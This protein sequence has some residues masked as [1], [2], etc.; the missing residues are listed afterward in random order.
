MP[1]R[2]GRPTE[3]ESLRIAR[4]PLIAEL[5]LACAASHAAL[6]LPPGDRNRELE[7]LFFRASASLE[8]FL[9]DW[10]VRCLSFDT[11]QFVDAFER[12]AEN[13]ALRDLGRWQPA[14]RLWGRKKRKPVVSVAIP[15]DNRLS[16]TEASAYLGWGGSTHSFRD[17]GELQK[18]AT[19][20]LALRFS[21]RVAQLTNGQKR[22]LDG[23]IKIRNLL[24][25]R[26][27]R[28]V[29]EMNQALAHAQLFSGLRRGAHSVSATG[30]GNY[31]R[32]VHTG[33]PRFHL[34]YEEMGKITYA[35]APGAPTPPI[36]P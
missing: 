17:A 25:H 5:Q 34:Y 18:D 9:T 21:N 13:Q 24:A 33:Q 1:R 2:R 10:F 31:L 14:N 19:Q 27:A 32:A 30:V 35:L 36:C 12:R 22:V 28:G 15:L 8:G 7:D 6:A 11:S 23:V 20:Y 4:E 16:Q 3:P 29:T 26:S